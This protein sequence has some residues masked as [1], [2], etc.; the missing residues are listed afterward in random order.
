VNYAKNRYSFTAGPVAVNLLSSAVI[1]YIVLNTETSTLRSVAGSNETNRSENEVLVMTLTFNEGL[2]V[3]KA[4]FATFE[5]TLN[6]YVPYVPF[7]KIPEMGN[8]G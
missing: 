6:S 1:Q 7:N 8:I 2:T 3:L 4:V 5:Y